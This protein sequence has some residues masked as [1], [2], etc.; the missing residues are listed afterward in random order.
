MRSKRAK[1][2][3]VGTEARIESTI[4]EQLLIDGGGLAD[5]NELHAYYLQ[6]LA[7]GYV[8]GPPE[9]D[10]G[11]RETPGGDA[12]IADVLR[13]ARKRRRKP[14]ADDRALA[15][16]LKANEALIQAIGPE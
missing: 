7:E 2:R 3:P 9:D 15:A 16:S 11:P 14:T 5:M 12:M 13:R 4:M 10:E 8:P 6:L 1:I